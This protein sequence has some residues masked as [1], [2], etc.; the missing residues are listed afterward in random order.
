MQFSPFSFYK[1]QKHSSEQQSAQ[2]TTEDNNSKIRRHISKYFL[3]RWL[4][5]SDTVSKCLT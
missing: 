1:N 5:L 4:D 2:P 3:M